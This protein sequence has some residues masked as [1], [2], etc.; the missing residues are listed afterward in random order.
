MK[1]YNIKYDFW[2]QKFNLI[3]YPFIFLSFINRDMTVST[4]GLVVLSC[5]VLLMLPTWFMKFVINRKTL[6]SPKIEVLNNM[7]FV[8]SYMGFINSYRI[9]EIANI[10]ELGPLIYIELKPGVRLIPYIAI[11]KMAIKISDL[12]QLLEILKSSKAVA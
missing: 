9:S 12:Y 3:I 6:K 10:K 1:I 5:A 8:K 7:L 2:F 11:S 4:G